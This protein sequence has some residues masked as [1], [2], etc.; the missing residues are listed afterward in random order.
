MKAKTP[1][2]SL[3]RTLAGGGVLIAP[4]VVRAGFIPLEKL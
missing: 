1:K 4:N 3:N 2:P